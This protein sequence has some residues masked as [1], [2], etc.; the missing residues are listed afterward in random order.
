MIWD[1]NWYEVKKITSSA[2]M[3]HCQVNERSKGYQF[4]L[5]VV[6]GLSTPEQRKSLWKE[7]ETLAKGISQPWLLV[8]D[9]NV[10][11]SAKDR[12]AG[13]PVAINEIK[14]FGECVRD[15]GVNALQWAGNYYT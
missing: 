15:M 10:I 6:Y 13:L 14:D 11:L 4:I 5:T 7:M 3:L 8:G 1:D 9:F 2:Q 12:L